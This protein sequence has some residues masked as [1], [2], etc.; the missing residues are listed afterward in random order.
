MINSLMLAV[1][2]VVRFCIV[3]V[4]HFFKKNMNIIL[5]SLDE[6][7]KNEKIHSGDITVEELKIWSGWKQHSELHCQ[8]T[9]GNLNQ[10][11]YA[12]SKS[13]TTK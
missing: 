7:F 1:G 2:S 9:S 10:T 6:P 8:L 13:G 11:W 3:F 5:T 12:K 4:A